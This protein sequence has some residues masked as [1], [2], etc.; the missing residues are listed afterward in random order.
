MEKLNIWRQMNYEIWGE[1]DA[2]MHEIMDNFLD[3]NALIYKCMDAWLD[4]LD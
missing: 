1:K 3:V 4:T 2:R